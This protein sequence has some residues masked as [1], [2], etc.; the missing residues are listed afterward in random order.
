MAEDHRTDAEDLASGVRRVGWMFTFAT[1]VYNLVR[2]R[3]LAIA[4]G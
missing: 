1:A 2:K 4:T 3:N